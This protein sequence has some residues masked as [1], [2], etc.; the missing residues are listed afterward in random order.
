[1]YSLLIL[2]SS[3]LSATCIEK[4]TDGTFDEALGSHKFVLVEFHAPWCGACDIFKPKY[5]EVYIFISFT[6][7]F[8]LFVSF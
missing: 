2:M 3:I 4:L 6:T 7:V 8:Y 5:D 1:M